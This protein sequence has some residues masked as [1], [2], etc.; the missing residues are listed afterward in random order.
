MSLKIALAF[1]ALMITANPN[2]LELA[3]TSTETANLLSIEEKK[4]HKEQFYNCLDAMIIES[5]LTE[6]AKQARHLFKSEE[7]N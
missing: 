6:D 5:S 2:E 3:T 1:I 7:Y 4:N